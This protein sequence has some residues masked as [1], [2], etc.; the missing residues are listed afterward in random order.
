MLKAVLF[1]LDGTLFD[2]FPLLLS[3][4]KMSARM[5]LGLETQDSDWLSLMG[6]PLRTQMA[7]FSEENADEMVRVYREYYGKQHD[8]MLRL[9]PGVKELVQNL[10]RSGL[11]L[12]VVTSKKTVFAV[13][14]LE[15]FQLEGCFEA[16]VGET[17]VKNH[18]P[19]AD[20]VLC[21]LDRLKIKPEEAIMVGD[22]SYDIDSAHAAG[23]RGIAVLWGAFS[24]EQLENSHPEY[25][26]NSM[27]ELEQLIRSLC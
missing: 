27:Q 26:A 6:L 22:A 8:K 14:G 24:R 1:D 10:D 15:L 12:A 3:G 4:Y 2:S 21:A 16:V 23:V 11:R 20:P 19:A 18:K 5:V 13:R 17:D 9:Y 25:Y 7:H